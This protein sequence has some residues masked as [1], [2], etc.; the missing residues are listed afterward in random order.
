MGMGW[1]SY[2]RLWLAAKNLARRVRW[3]GCFDPPRV[4]TR[5]CAAHVHLLL[6]T[7][8]LIYLTQV[9][10]VRN[11]AAVGRLRGEDDAGAMVP[12]VPVVACC[13]VLVTATEELFAENQNS[14]VVIVYV[15]DIRPGQ[16]PS[17]SSILIKL[18][19]WPLPV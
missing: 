16:F 5:C 10:L 6:L 14:L 19:L 4:Y 15:R 9:A 1:R 7:S 11:R 2:P 8:Y 12:I 13:Q 3:A 18:R 17:V